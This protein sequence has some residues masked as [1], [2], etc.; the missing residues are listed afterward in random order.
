MSRALVD[1][2][3]QPVFIEP[4]TPQQVLEFAN[5]FDYLPI[6]AFVA[7]LPGS[8]RDEYLGRPLTEL[9]AGFQKLTVRD[10]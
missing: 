8:H 5:V 6:A 2:Y 4:R 1:L 3:Q 7:S 9:P 10:E